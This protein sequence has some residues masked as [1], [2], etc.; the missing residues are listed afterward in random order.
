MTGMTAHPTPTHEALAAAAAD[1]SLPDQIL[2]QWFG[3]AR[4]GNTD[5]LQHK[6]QWF[7]KS[8]AFDEQLRERFDVAVE[9]AIGGA[10]QHW[11]AQGPWQHLALVLLL[12]QFTRHLFRH[13]PRSFAGD[14]QALTL[15]LQAMQSGAD[16]QLPEVARVFMY[17]PL[18]HAEDPAMQARSVAAFEALHQAATDA[19]LR[20]YLAGSLD[21]AYRHQVVIEKFCRFPHRNA[22]LGRTS[23]A[24]ETEYL[25]QPGAGF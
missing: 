8:P 16:Q 1:T 6:A 2:S 4:P 19:E 3:S 17:L 10:L 21:Y 14:P 24:A 15:A 7:N 11:S 5:A 18:E 20:E 22:I 23:T 13:N 25:A 9:A 12:D